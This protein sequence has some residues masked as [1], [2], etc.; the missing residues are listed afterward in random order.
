[1]GAW[2]IGHAG[3]AGHAALTEG[4]SLLFDGLHPI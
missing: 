2:E 1:M 4:H 3:H